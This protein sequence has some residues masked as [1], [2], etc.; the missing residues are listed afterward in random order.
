M[1]RG[2]LVASPLACFLTAERLVGSREGNYRSVG[3]VLGSR[4]GNDGAGGARPGARAGGEARSLVASVGSAA[5][6]R[7]NLPEIHSYRRN[8]HVVET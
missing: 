4:E 2:I 1:G 3:R 5:R 6:S 8:F 7:E